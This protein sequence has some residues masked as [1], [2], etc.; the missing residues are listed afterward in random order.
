[1]LQDVRYAVRA[2]HRNPSFTLVVVATFALGIGMNTAVFSVANAVM[3]R[4]LPYP[5]QTGWL[6]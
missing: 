5:M 6:G 3:F 2:L 4:A 1:M